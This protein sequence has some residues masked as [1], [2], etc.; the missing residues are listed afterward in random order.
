MGISYISQYDSESLS[1]YG[2]ALTTQIDMWAGNH[3][4]KIYNAT[5]KIFSPHKENGP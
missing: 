5:M 4:E 2:T 1:L 3:S